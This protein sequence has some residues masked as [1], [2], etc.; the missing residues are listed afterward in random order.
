MKPNLIFI[1]MR[2]FTFIALSVALAGGLCQQAYAAALPDYMKCSTKVRKAANKGAQAKD[3]TAAKDVRRMTPAK[4]ADNAP[5]WRARTQKA[6]GWNG[7]DWELM[8]TYDI[9]YDEAGRKMVQTVT[10]IEGYVNRESY[11]WNEDGELATRLTQ[12]DED[13]SGEFADYGRL[14]RTYDSR[15]TSFI[16]SNEQY[17]YSNGDWMP[18][19]CY[20]QTITRDAAGN[21]TQMERAVYYDGMYDPV[22]RLNIAYGEDGKAESIVENDLTYDYSENE[23]LWLESAR[24]YDIVWEETDGQIV[25]VDDLAGMFIGAN[26]LKSAKLDIEGEIYDVSVEYAG[27]DFVVNMVSEP[28]DEGMVLISYVKYS[29]MDFAGESSNIGWEIVT[30]NELRIGDEVLEKMEVT[31]TD[32]YSPDGLLLLEKVEFSDGELSEIDSML[33]GVVEY[34]EEYGYPLA[35]TVSEYD[36]ETGEMYESFRAEFSDY[37]DCAV[38]GMSEIAAP[39]ASAPV[40]YNIHGQRVDN[41]SAGIFI[42]VAGDRTEKVIIR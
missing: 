9:A 23:Y 2:N 35:W 17:L 34:D 33:D 25:S 42:R 31:E 24:Y 7:E 39:A 26:R 1:F 40:F 14:A 18:S 30:V 6:F 15:I 37:T 28:D 29:E 22:Y 36:W 4:S 8:E 27:N 11:T 5:M 12:V 20:T 16:T 13:G 38:S 21:V 3:R 19:N 32:I 41:P 10:D